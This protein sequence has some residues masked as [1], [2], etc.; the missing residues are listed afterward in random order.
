MKTRLLSLLAATALLPVSLL[1][2]A[3]TTATIHGHVNNAAGQTIKGAKVLLTTDKTAEAA[4]QKIKNTFDVDD[5]GDYKG[6]GIVPGD[7]LGI[8][9]ADGKA[10][11]DYAEFT[12]KAGDDKVV[13]F[14]MTR[15]EYIDKMTPEEKTALEEYK[16]NAG[17][18]LASNKVVANLNA[19]LARVRGDLKAAGA[20]AYGDVSK[21]VDDMKQATDAKPD[22]SILWVTYGDTLQA[23]GDHLAKQDRADHKPVTGDETA[24]KAYGDS[25]T[26]FSKG[27]D[28]NAAAKKPD[29]LI[30]ASAWNQAGN[31]LAKMGKIKEASDAFEKAAKLQP[32]NAGM[33]YANEAA[34]LFNAS[35]SGADTLPAAAAAADKAIAADP[36]RADAYYI[37]GQALISKATVDKNGKYILPPGCIEAYTKYIELTPPEN[38]RVAEV[39]AI[40]TGMG[41]T[42]TTKYKAPSGK[43]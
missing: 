31:A 28:L 43:R 16:K 19:T 2:Q 27:A 13:N 41:E 33:Y 35:N 30:Q 24:M 22:E 40:L 1:A 29:V 17:A 3:P 39:K 37:K 25:V 15:K 6:A 32:A 11:V 5:N 8:V 34:I 9:L 23:Q 18:A 12:V 10:R 21:D 4:N 20:P 14:D 7:Y 42:V 26:A 38:P 36:N